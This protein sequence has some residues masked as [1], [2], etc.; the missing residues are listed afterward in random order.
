MSG[1][2]VMSSA[3]NT[4]IGSCIAGLHR[5]GAVVAAQELVGI[6]METALANLCSSFKCQLNVLQFRTGTDELEEI[7][8]AIADG[9]WTCEQK[10][11]LA[12]AAS[13]AARRECERKTNARRKSQKCMSFENYLT[14][15]DWAQL[16]RKMIDNAAG[17]LIANRAASVKMVNPCEFTLHHMVKLVAFCQCWSAVP[18]DVDQNRVTTLKLKIQSMIKNRQTD[19]DMPYLVQ[20]AALCN[21]DGR[22]VS[23]LRGSSDSRTQKLVNVT[24]LQIISEQNTGWNDDNDFASHLEFSHTIH[25]YTLYIS[26]LIKTRHM[27]SPDRHVSPISGLYALYPFSADDLPEC[28]KEYAYGDLSTVPV[29]V[30]IPELEN[31]LLGTSPRGAVWPWD[32]ARWIVVVPLVIF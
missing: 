28:I 26:W 14:D 24:E 27:S 10:R 7:T 15:S 21:V 13:S 4:M 17:S 19:G 30:H 29:I 3:A 32:H 9:P 25:H 18:S 1:A 22:L 8:R 2:L 12:E 23:A 6:P 31:D 11:L 20:Y 16:R 5:A